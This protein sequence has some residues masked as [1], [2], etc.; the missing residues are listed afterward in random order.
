MEL[1]D[2][3]VLAPNVTDFDDLAVAVAPKLND[4]F[5]LG[6]PTLAAAPAKGLLPEAL[7][8]PKVFVVVEDATAVPNG[9][10]LAFTA[11]P[12][13]GGGGL[14]TVVELL[15]DAPNNAEAVV[16]GVDPKEG[17]AEAF[18]ADA[19][20]ENKDVPDGGA[21]VLLA[22]LETEVAALPNVKGD[23]A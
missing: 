17:R 7:N 16:A 15:A 5:A 14:L 2:I 8:D 18:D 1:P 23:V 4:A 11:D 19:P 21:A 6:A 3:T 20:K 13:L 12:K 9:G 10:G 22:V